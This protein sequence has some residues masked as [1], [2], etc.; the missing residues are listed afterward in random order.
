MRLEVEG[1][2][3]AVRTIGPVEAEG[4]P[5]SL[6]LVVVEGSIEVEVRAGRLLARSSQSEGS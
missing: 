3:L 2:G 5:G 6:D 4:S 1:V